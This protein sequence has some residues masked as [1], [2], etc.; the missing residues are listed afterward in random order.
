MLI[1][2]GSATGSD[3]AG[4]LVWMTYGARVP[5]SCVDSLKQNGDLPDGVSIEVD[6]CGEVSVEPRGAWSN[7]WD[8]ETSRWVATWCPHEDFAVADDFDVNV[9]AMAA[10]RRAVHEVG[11]LPVLETRLPTFNG[12]CIPKEEVGRALDELETFRLKAAGA[13]LHR[14]IDTDTNRV[15]RS[16]AMSASGVF[17]MS[18]TH[19]VEFG[20]D[21]DGFYVLHDQAPRTD[22]FERPIGSG[23]TVIPLDALPP[24]NPKQPVEVFRARRVQQIPDGPAVGRAQPT[25]F[26]DQDTGREVR[27]PLAMT[28]AVQGPDGIGI[29]TIPERFHVETVPRPADWFDFMLVPLRRILLVAL[30]HDAP[31]AWT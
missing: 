24:P 18:A 28:T 7:E 1:H 14:M 2:D 19:G 26:V 10:F 25:R 21:R 17:S 9:W 27:L 20:F 6:P 13:P 12:G 3:V 30:E 22:P 15:L 8:E 23:V 31:L 5:C 4:R 29:E 11:D 16:L